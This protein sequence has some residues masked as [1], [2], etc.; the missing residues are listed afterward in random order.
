MEETRIDRLE[1][2]FDEL[3]AEMRSG[4]RAIDNRLC[5]IE[6]GLEQTV[7]KAELAALEGQMELRLAQCAT[8]S[9]L[10]DLRNEMLRLNAELKA[11]MLA[12]ALTIIAS[13]LAIQHWSG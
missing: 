3:A 9:E 6:A 12:T 4:F 13:S 7:T 2:R 1:G 5:K 8:K 11:W 10:N